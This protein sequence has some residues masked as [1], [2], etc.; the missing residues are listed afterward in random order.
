MLP[1]AALQ[2]PTPVSRSTSKTPMLPMLSASRSSSSLFL[3][4]EIASWRLVMSVNVAK[5]P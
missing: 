5:A 2:L 3:R 4:A 1:I